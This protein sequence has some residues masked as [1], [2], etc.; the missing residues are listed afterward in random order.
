MATPKVK[1]DL[2]GKGVAPQQPGEGGFSEYAGPELVKGSYPAKIK[3]VVVGK[4][5]ENA[6]PGSKKSANHGKP[7]ISILLE[8]QTSD[9]P[10][11]AKYHGHPI[12]DGLNIIDGG[13]GFVNAFLHSLTN[14]SESQKR[15]IESAF[16]D[17]DKGPDFKRVKVEKGPKAGT[18]NTH[19]VKIG[20]AVLG[21]PGKG[22]FMVQVIAKPDHDLSGAFKAA[23]T[24]YLP[25]EGEQDLPEDDDDENEDDVDDVED[26]DEDEDD[27]TGLE[28]DSDDEDDE[29]AEDDDVDSD[30]EDEDDDSDD[31]D[32]D[33]D[34]EP[35]PPVKAGAKK[36]VF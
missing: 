19:I 30:D 25:Y 33:E 16:W 13:Q 8:V 5:G 31:D 28:S 12:W 29:D 15:A 3:R 18:I 4:I 20:R 26:D 9:I 32:E 22:Q 2:N 17:D 7:R 1:W 36:R 10:D 6:K 14:G 23:I 11:K 24:E 35:E 34:A 27:D 21:P